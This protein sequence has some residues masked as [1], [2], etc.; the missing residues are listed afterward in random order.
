[1]YCQISNIRY[2]PITK[3]KCFSCHLALVNIWV[4]NNFIANLDVTL[5]VVRALLGSNKWLG[6]KK[7]IEQ[8]TITHPPTPIK[9]LGQFS[10]FINVYQILSAVDAL[11][12][13]VTRTSAAVVLTMQ[14]LVFHM[15]WL[16][17]P[18]LS[19]YRDM[20]ENAN[21]LFMFPKI[22]TIQGLK[23]YCPVRPYCDID[24]SQHWLR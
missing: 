1:M 17:L 20:I 13:C 10:L 24:H 22:D 2:S 21:I 16:Q 9:T 23:H 6:E 18:L 12:P 4:I 14:V 5:T 8:I 3:L 19:Q 7:K 11:A 15:E